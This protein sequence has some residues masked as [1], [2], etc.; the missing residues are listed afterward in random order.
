MSK[1][2]NVNCFLRQQKSIFISNA[3][4]KYTATLKH[5]KFH[6][7]FSKAMSAFR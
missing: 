5:P 7:D 1:L 2:F 4:L 6:S 3:I